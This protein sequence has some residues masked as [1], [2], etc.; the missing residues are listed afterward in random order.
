MKYLREEQ[1]EYVGAGAN[2]QEA[3]T[4]VLI[5]RSGIK[6]AFLGFSRVVPNADWKARPL[7]RPRA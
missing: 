5:E 4:P 7:F 6:V 3:F 2:E 1:I